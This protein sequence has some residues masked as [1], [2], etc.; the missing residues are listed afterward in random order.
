[1]RAGFPSIAGG[2]PTYEKS[3]FS[4]AELCPGLFPE[5]SRSGI[6]SSCHE[7]CR[8]FTIGVRAHRQSSSLT[9]FLSVSG[10]RSTGLWAHP[11]PSITVRIWSC[12]SN[13][14]SSARLLDPKG[15]YGASKIVQIFRL[16][17][18]IRRILSPFCKIN[19][20]VF[21]LYSKNVELIWQKG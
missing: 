12:V 11:F 3:V 20:T 6:F 10:F 8:D 21:E 7:N 15:G 13:V 14:M 2:K 19:S 9:L 16:Y 18:F 5:K 17:L 4:R 1:M